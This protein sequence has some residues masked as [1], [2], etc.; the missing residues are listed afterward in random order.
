M[1]V[2][3]EVAGDSDE[4]YTFL[5]VCYFIFEVFIS[6]IYLQDD[7]KM[8][9]ETTINNDKDKYEKDDKKVKKESKEK[10]TNKKKYDKKLGNYLFV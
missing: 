5:Y 3:D 1:I 8:D 2:C 9:A 10:E 4:V 7:S 6:C